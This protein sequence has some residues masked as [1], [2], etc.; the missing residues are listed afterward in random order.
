[1]VL[2]GALQS[3]IMILK[4]YLDRKYRGGG[5]LIAVIS[6]IFEVIFLFDQTSLL[7]LLDTI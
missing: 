3:N 6:W 4:I 2:N 5:V 1:M 7:A